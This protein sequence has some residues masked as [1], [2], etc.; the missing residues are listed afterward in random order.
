MPTIAPQPL[1]RWDLFCRVIDNHGDLGVCWRLARDLVSRGHAVRLWVDDPAA[2][3]WMVPEWPAGL[4]V[5]H[6]RQP[7]AVAGSVVL[8]TGRAVDEAWHADV[9]VEAFGC[10]IDPDYAA[11]QVPPAAGAAAARRWI[12]LEY[13][14]AESYVERSHGLPSPVMSGPAAG[15]T[16]FFV[17]PGFTPRT[18]G[19]LREPD[20]PARQHAFNAADWLARQGIRHAAGERLISLFCY[21]PAP[22]A[23]WLHTLADGT[24]RT[25]LLVTPGRPRQAVEAAGFATGRDALALD[26]LPHLP[27]PRFDEL[28]WCCDLNLVRGEDSLV[29]ALWAG[30]PFVW[31]LYP[32]DDGAHIPKLNAFLDFWLDGAPPA[33]AALVRHWHQAW[34]GSEPADTL[35]SLDDAQLQAWARWAQEARARLWQQDDLTTQLIRFTAPAPSHVPD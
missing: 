13:L 21:E 26:F 23:G 35:P 2:L 17:Y 11:R 14:S 5:I 12:N 19:L 7:P 20:L 6:W 28:L 34:N 10:E 18:G 16:K 3:A 27:Q 31:H 25:R 22:L 15:R 33:L 29:R 1:R 9:L 8:D 32:Q 24:D 4:D 30:R